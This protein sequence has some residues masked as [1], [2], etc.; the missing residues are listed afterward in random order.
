M[1]IDITS[2]DYPLQPQHISI[3]TGFWW[4]AFGNIETE[5][6]AQWIIRFLQQRGEGWK[7]FRH[8]DLEAF[9]TPQD[10]FLYNNLITEGFVQPERNAE[11]TP[12]VSP[13]CLMSVTHKFIVRCFLV[14]PF[15][16]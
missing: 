13:Q 16:P 15:I 1:S 5:I 2:P 14:A 3:D 8:S 11:G 10:G 9:Y 4:G 6:S 7:P 12:L